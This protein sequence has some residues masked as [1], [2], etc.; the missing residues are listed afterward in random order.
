MTHLFVDITDLYYK[1]LKKFG[2]GKLNYEKYLSSFDPDTKIAYGCQEENEAAPFIR[3]LR[4]LGFL[5]K[6]KHPYTLKI[7]DRDIK[8]CNWLVGI[9]I[10]VVK[11]V[12]SGAGHIVIGTSNPDIIPLVKYLRAKSI[13][14]TIFAC[15]I[16]KSL[17]G[18]CTIIEITED[19]L[20]ETNKID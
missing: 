2:N 16:P 14:V 7:G 11:A 18:L 12:E 13:K 19:N 4:S 9:T 8:R 17:E 15:N 10:D 1:L 6:Y 5:T 20:N 3:Y